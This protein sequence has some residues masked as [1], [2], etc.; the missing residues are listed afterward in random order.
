MNDSTSRKFSTEGIESEIETFRRLSKRI[1]TLHNWLMTSSLG[2]FAFA[3]TVLLQIGSAD[4]GFP[5]IG[6][7]SVA[8]LAASVFLAAFNKFIFEVVDF[9][10]DART[11]GP[12]LERLAE[13]L[14]AD[15]SLSPSEG[16]EISQLLVRYVEQL[17]KANAERE[18]FKAPSLIPLITNLALLVIGTAMFC[19][20][21]L[22]ALFHGLHIT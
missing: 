7:L 15:D 5:W 10:S 3:L 14:S 20:H 16:T 19:L 11:L 13:F 18:P 9:E 6:F 2:I 12:L 17:S 22:A 21:V 4:I 1:R 8:V